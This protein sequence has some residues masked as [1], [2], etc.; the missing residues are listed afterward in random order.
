MTQAVECPHPVVHS[1]R[2]GGK[3][4]VRDDFQGREKKHPFPPEIG[5]DLAGRLFRSGVRRGK[6]KDRPL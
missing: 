3:S 4:F 6:E 2:V 5:G 1:R